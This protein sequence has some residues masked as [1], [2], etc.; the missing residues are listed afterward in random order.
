MRA[1]FSAD[2]RKT[3]TTNQNSLHPALELK[4]LKQQ[5]TELQRTFIKKKTECI[6]LVWM[7][8]C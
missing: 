1:F 6:A 7:L 2:K 4:H 8:Y 3:L 5:V